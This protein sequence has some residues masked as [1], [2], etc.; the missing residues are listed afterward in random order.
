MHYGNCDKPNSTGLGKAL[1]QPRNN[2]LHNVASDL[3]VF[4]GIGMLKFSEK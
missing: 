3:Q 1:N 4:F 2:P